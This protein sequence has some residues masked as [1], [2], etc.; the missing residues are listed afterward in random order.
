MFSSRRLSFKVLVFVL[1][2]AILGTTSAT[3]SKSNNQEK[4]PNWKTAKVTYEDI[5]TL[6]TSSSTD[7]SDSLVSD[8]KLQDIL[9]KEASE[10]SELVAFSGIKTPD[11]QKAYANSILVGK[12]LGKHDVYYVNF[13][14]EKWTIVATYDIDRDLLI[15]AVLLDRADENNIKVTDRNVGV[16]FEGTLAELMIVKDGSAEEVA[17]IKA[18]QNN[19]FFVVK[20]K[21]TTEKVASMLTIETA[22][23]SHVGGFCGNDGYGNPLYSSEV[24]GWTAVFYCAAA[25]LLGFWPGL[26]CAATTMYGCTYQCK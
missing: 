17:K 23:A 12:S 5:K 19:P 26:L 8:K 9:R 20:E 4:P 21:S 15:G 11:L 22:S 7:H 25:G 3:A 18:K 1:I 13:E 10:N 6:K 2:V 16:L 24:C 14:S